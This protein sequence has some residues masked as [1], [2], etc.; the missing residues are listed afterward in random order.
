MRGAT[1]KKNKK[2]S[3]LAA[4]WGR[5]KKNKMAVLGL[6]IL[7][8]IVLAAIFADVFFDYEAMAVQQSAA[9]RLKPPSAQHLLGTDN[10]GRDILSRVMA[11]SGSTF[12]VAVCTVLIGCVFG[13]IV[14]A[15]TGYFGGFFDNLIMRFNDILLSFPSIL[16]A[17]IFISLTKPG[18]YNII[19]ALG[20]LFIP[21]FARI[22]RS[23]VI[24]CREL[25]F[26]KS[27]R[28]LGA[29][30]IR[31]IFAHILPNAAVSLLTAA[32]IGFNNAVLAEASMSYLG[33]GIQ[34]P[35]PS[36]GRMLYEAQSYLFNAPWYAIGPGVTIILIILGFSM[37]SEGL[38][39]MQQ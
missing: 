38:R 8:L 13:T 31:I 36:L 12:F 14:G 20:I 6:A 2:K 33:L 26:V 28:I 18:S 25:D 24:R 3:Q 19:L 29:G 7:C 32:A 1:M 34:P 4:V 5:L 23:E 22:V 10:F 16:L 17:L 9:L 27:A 30:H 21:S 15:L 39:S 11:G 35:E 37:V